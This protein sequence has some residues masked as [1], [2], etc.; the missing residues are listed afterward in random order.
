MASRRTISESAGAIAAIIGADR[1]SE[2][3]FKIVSQ[4]PIEDAYYIAWIRAGDI[5]VLMRLREWRPNGEVIAPLS[6]RYQMK[7]EVEQEFQNYQ[8]LLG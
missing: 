8:T 3:L 4:C 5:N 7:A 2:Q 1:Q 6:I